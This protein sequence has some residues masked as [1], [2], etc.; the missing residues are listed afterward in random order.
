MRALRKALADIR[1][2]LF[3]RRLFKNMRRAH[4]DADD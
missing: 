2:W 1:G 4:V 3:A